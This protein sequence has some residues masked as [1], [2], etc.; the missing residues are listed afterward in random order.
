MT[1][2]RLAVL[3]LFLL[4]IGCG[5]SPPPAADAPDP[6]TAAPAATTAAPEPEI[7]PLAGDAQVR[8]VH[9]AT[10][11]TA[12]PI[13]V[14]GVDMAAPLFP[15]AAYK[16]P[17][18]YA[19]VATSAGDVALAA[20]GQGLAEATTQA[21]VAPGSHNTVFVISDPENADGLQLVAVDDDAPRAPAETTRVRF[22]HAL[23]GAAT[24]DVCVAGEGRAPATLLF[25]GVA[26][27]GLAA[28]LDLPSP[29]PVRLQI[30]QASE[31][32][33]AGR[34]IGVVALAATEEQPLLGQNVTL[35]ALGA[36]RQPRGRPDVDREVLV[37]ID[38][39]PQSRSMTLPI[40]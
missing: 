14:F 37:S 33:C 17:T 11:A 25:P 30:R 10:R 15:G 27:G 4:A 19:K 3:A 2:R 13:D 26:Y 29:P 32:E 18:A 34:P 23:A 40:R 8:F 31:N 5:G 28:Y 35:V 6:G 7:D 36:L 39:P 20:R 24:V 9:V 22:F 21:N 16:A 38:Q 1:A 12:T